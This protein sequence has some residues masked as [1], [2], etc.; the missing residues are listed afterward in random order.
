MGIKSEKIKREAGLRA[1]FSRVKKKMR[2]R[3]KKEKKHHINL[4]EC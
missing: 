4:T 1:G 3:M 2:E